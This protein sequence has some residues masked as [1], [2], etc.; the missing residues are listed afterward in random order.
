MKNSAWYHKLWRKK[1]DE[2]VVKENADLAWMDMNKMLNHHMPINGGSSGGNFTPKPLVAKV[3]G[4]L[5][6][7]TSAAFIVGAGVYLAVHTK[8]KSKIHKRKQNIDTVN[9][10]ITQPVNGGFKDTLNYNTHQITNDS[11][12]L[13][14]N[15][16][17]S[18]LADSASNYKQEALI[19]KTINQQTTGNRGTDAVAKPPKN[20]VNQLAALN[21]TD[22]VIAGA[23]VVA[24]QKQP[25]VNS[26]AD[27]TNETYTGQSDKSSRTSIKDHSAKNTKSRSGKD[28]KVTNKNPGTHIPSRFNYGLEGG[29]STAARF[30]NYYFGAFGSYGLT[31]KL[32]IGIG[33][34]LDLNRAISG[35]HTHRSYNRPD[36]LTFL[37][38]DYRKVNSIVFPVLLEYK[39]SDKISIHGGPH[40]NYLLKQY[41]INSKLGAV[42]NIRDT[43]YHTASI[44]SALKHNTINKVTFGVSAGVS[45]RVGQFN[46]DGTY[47]QGITPYKVNTGLGTYRQKYGTLQ[48]GVR[49]KF[50]K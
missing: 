30:Q 4:V 3:A 13:N 18:Q 39:L 32:S 35:A 15:A 6:Y 37:I 5:G 22:T 40:L 10:V 17:T 46:I 16:I 43:L 45:L 8:S 36:S 41:D 47:Q 12:K 31:E 49:Y 27:K 38:K 7:L 11:T 24:S 21:N 25:D 44:D 29:L 19:N 26:A 28:K 34:R 42:T 2:L 50:K 20:G 1:L 23:D 33:A 9:Q 14:G 48:I